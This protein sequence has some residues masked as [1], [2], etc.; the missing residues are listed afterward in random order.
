MSKFIASS[1]IRAGGILA[2][3]FRVQRKLQSGASPTYFEAPQIQV[4]VT[5]NW[6]TKADF[7]VLTGHI[8]NGNWGM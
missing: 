2:H 8:L 4:G 5:E 7:F 1:Q 6:T 3:Y